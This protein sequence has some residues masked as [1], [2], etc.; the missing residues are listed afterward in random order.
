MNNQEEKKIVQ[1]GS[2]IRIEPPTEMIAK[3]KEKEAATQAQ[4]EPKEQQPQSE[5]NTEQELSFSQKMPLL[6]KILL[7]FSYLFLV[8]GL[9]IGIIAVLD[10]PVPKFIAP[11]VNLIG[12][13]FIHP[14]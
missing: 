1:S 12:N 4:Q 13:F 8:A 5:V 10:I 3:M 7:I 6:F 11:V 9:V 14:A 2:T